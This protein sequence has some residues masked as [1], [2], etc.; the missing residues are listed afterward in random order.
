M[1]APELFLLVDVP[2]HLGAVGLADEEAP[3][4]LQYCAEGGG[5]ARGNGGGAGVLQRLEEGGT[6][7]P[8]LQ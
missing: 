8:L 4:S 7:T 6:V 1:S 2:E 3:A 5:R